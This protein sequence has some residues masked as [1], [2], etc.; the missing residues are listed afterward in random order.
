MFPVRP[1]CLMRY[2]LGDLGV[3]RI[4]EH[5]VAEDHGWQAARVSHLV[6][7]SPALVGVMGQ[8]LAAD[9]VARG[10]IEQ[11]LRAR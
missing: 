6:Q 8:E 7:Q 4:A 9:G 3:R 11:L 10:Q 2:H 5:L 1:I